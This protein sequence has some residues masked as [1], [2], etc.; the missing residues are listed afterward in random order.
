VV[1]IKTLRLRERNT[2]D[3]SQK[4]FEREA[5]L[6]SRLDHPNLISV[7]DFGYTNSGDPYLVMDFVSGR[8]LFD[9]MRRE[10]YLT[11][12]RV[13]N[14]FSQVCD[15]LFHAHQRGVI[16]RDLKPAIYWL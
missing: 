13:V 6:T 8:P 4:R 10:H 14:L 12:E 9:I 11:P 2:D 16:H 3:R 5:R 15:G 1:A 7:H